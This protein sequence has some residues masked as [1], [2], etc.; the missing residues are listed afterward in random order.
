MYA[1][2]PG[3]V[4]PNEF[5]RAAAAVIIA[6]AVVMTVA[7]VLYRDWHKGAL[8]AAILMVALFA[9]DRLYSYV[10]PLQF[11]G[12]RP[13]RRLV[14]LPLTYAV[15]AAC[16]WWI[17]RRPRPSSR[18]TAL[19]NV[20]TAGCLLIPSATLVRSHVGA[21]QADTPMLPLPRVESRAVAKPDIYYVVFDRYGDDRTIRQYGF[22]NTPFYRY[23][24]E[25]GFYV[26]GD[27]RSNYLKTV[28]SLASSLNMSY[29]DP[30]QVSE[31]VDSDNWWPVFDWVQNARVIGFLKAQGY[32]YVHVGSWYWPTTTNALADRNVN[33]Y[34]AVPYAALRLL[35]SE[36]MAPAR[37]VFGTSWLSTRRQQW[38]RVHRGVEEVVRAAGEGGPTFTF[39]HILVPH[40]PY[41][42]DADRTYV[43]ADEESRRSRDRNYT[44]QVQAA[45]AFARDLIDGILARAAA[46]P[47]II[48]QGDEGPYPA[49]TTGDRYNWRTA[50]SRVLQE[51]SGILN[52]YYLPGLDAAALYPSV[53]PVNSFRIV[54][55][56]YFGTRLELLPDRVVGHESDYR[57]YSFFDLTEVVRTSRNA[58]GAGGAVHSAA[59]VW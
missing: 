1:V 32:R 23:L 6:A 45:N 59:Q 19:A 25:K 51:K 43:S 53:S 44:N 40:S 8:L 18:F 38:H 35:D 42:F 56:A 7:S 15:L 28:L 29:L 22:D 33:A 58:A 14:A 24:V 20:V 21:A 48:L 17:W 30:L 46:P 13:A 26:A 54:F 52:A 4:T 57:P 39:V 11:A 10:E 37:L 34:S 27:S 12:V 41:V 47:V 36:L 5:A 55:N 50:T 16:A 49:G 9:F 31:G 2:N 3:A